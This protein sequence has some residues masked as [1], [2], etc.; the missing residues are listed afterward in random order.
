MTT[1][2][3][4]EKGFV[5]FALLVLSGGIDL[6]NEQFGFV[7][8]S[9]SQGSPISR[10][11]EACIHLGV[12]FFSIVYRRKLFLTPTRG[13]FLGILFLIILVSATWSDIP[14][15]T[16]RRSISLL[17]TACFGFYFGKRFTLN[18]QLHLLAWM[19]GIAVVLSFLTA[20]LLPQ[21]GV[22]GRGISITAETIAHSGSWRGIY[23]HKNVLGRVMVLSSMVF[24]LLAQGNQK[25]RWVAWTG[26]ILSFGLIVLC[27]SKTSIV[28]LFTLMI[29]VNLYK[30]LRLN[31]TLLIPFS[32]SIVS[33]AGV[34]A[35]II[36]GIAEEV[37]GAMG[38]DM[39]LT[40]RTELWTLVIEKIGERPWGGY[41]FNAFWLGVGSPSEIIWRELNWEVPHSHN[42]FLDLC[43]D[44]GLIGLL[45]FILAFS[46]V[47][48]RGIAWVRFTRNTD[49]LWPITYLS[50]LVLANLT[51]SSLLRQKFL[52]VLLVSITLSI[53]KI[54]GETYQDKGLG[55]VSPQLLVN[56]ENRMT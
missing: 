45:V 11:M 39:T 32:I 34:T 8:A 14:D 6:L 41:G 55:Q 56:Q 31:Y 52:I 43:L 21:Y 46:L 24:F 3:L 1:I 53:P 26:F 28:I 47:Y 35:T 33:L 23:I 49:S 30:S 16:L 42:G 48:L 38:K 25:Y 7:G 2:R 15:L 18:E 37:L 5:I 36:L 12:I 4:L 51:E 44:I 10:G 40:G 17:W 29:L 9:A 50:F 22:M 20:A 13:K 27:T 19:C 54:W